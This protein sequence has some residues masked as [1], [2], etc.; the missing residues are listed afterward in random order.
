MDI[1][2][3]KNSINS[4]Q[5]SF[6]ARLQLRGNISL[7]DNNG[8]KCLSKTIDKIGSKTDIIDINLP[9]KFSKNKA[10]VTIAGY[11][12]GALEQFSVSIE[13]NNVLNGIIS[14]LQN[15]KK[16][17]PKTKSTAKAKNTSPKEII[18]ALVD[19]KKFNEKL[20]ELVEAQSDL[21]KIEKL[22]EKLDDLKK[23]YD[24]KLLKLEDEKLSKKTEN[25][26]E[27]MAKAIL[28]RIDNNGYLEYRL[29]RCVE[30][31]LN[32]DDMA[33]W[34]ADKIARKICDRDGCRMYAKWFK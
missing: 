25:I 3:N 1:K 15:A 29:A 7:L 26:S 24:K 32:K 12:N 33:Y 9:E 4:I 27:E 11:V 21:S 28:E 18:N 14:C 17:F 34:F 10:N 2:L 6:R 16:L 30:H 22:S 13:K 20:A 31:A 5:P 8:V 23:C 19:D